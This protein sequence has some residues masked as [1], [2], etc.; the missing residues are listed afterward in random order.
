M[1]D[2]SGSKPDQDLNPDIESLICIARRKSQAGRNS[3]FETIQDLFLQ[4]QGAL[5]DR[6]RALM[7]GIL[8]HLIHEVEI[9]VRKDLAKRLAK[10]DDTPRELVLALAN[11]EIEVAHPMLIDSTVLHDADLIELVRHRTQAHQLAIAM[12]SS[13]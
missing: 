3:I 1:T 13:L 5:S 12:R 9:T 7:G 4:K 6:E 10:R 8:R 11:D 2:E